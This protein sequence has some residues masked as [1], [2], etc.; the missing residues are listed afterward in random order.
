MDAS[1][2]SRRQTE[3]KDAVKVP[4]VEVVG[5]ALYAQLVL[6]KFWVLVDV[7]DDLKILSMLSIVTQF[8]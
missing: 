1:L 6:E 2:V 8:L 4:V 3:S 5:C 7:A